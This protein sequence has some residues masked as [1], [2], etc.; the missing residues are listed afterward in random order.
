M[1]N[2]KIG[3]NA[4]VAAGSVVTKDVPAGAIVG[5]NPARIIGNYYDLADRRKK[6]YPTKELWVELIEN[7]FLK[8]GNAKRWNGGSCSNRF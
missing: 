7:F 6:I 4:I 5:G 8:D 1:Y 3:P 2:V